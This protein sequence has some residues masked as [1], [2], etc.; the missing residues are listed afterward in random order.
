MKYDYSDRDP[1]EQLTENHYYQYHRA[2]WLSDGIDLKNKTLYNNDELSEPVHN[3]NECGQA[4]D[5]FFFRF[6]QIHL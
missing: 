2:A 5:L 1:V 6:Y 4:D 3:R